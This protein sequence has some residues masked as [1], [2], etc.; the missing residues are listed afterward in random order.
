M[1]NERSQ[2]RQNK[3]RWIC[4]KRGI[5]DED[6]YLRTLAAITHEEYMHRIQPL[7]DMK[8]RVLMFKLPHYLVY[9]DGRFDA[10]PIKYTPEEAKFL[11]QVD[12]LIAGVA[13]ELGFTA[14]PT[15]PPSPQPTPATTPA[16]PGSTPPAPR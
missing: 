13:R 11:A 12:E 9:P 10:M 1:V 5:T 3:A 16:E 4:D 8:S 14:T 7:L 2:M 15:P 6:G